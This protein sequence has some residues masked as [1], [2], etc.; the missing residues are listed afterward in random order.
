LQ[1]EAAAEKRTAK[2]RQMEADGKIKRYYGPDNPLWK[3]GHEARLRRYVESG[4]SAEQLRRYRAANPHKARE[5]AQNRRNRKVGK[6]PYGTVPRIGDAQKWRCAICGTGIR[7]GYHVDHIMPIARGGKHEP[8]NIQLL[9]ES[10]NVR[11]N[12]KD[13]IQ[14][15][16]EIGRLL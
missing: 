12:A 16:Q 11:K 5:W 8:R 10:C 1:S 15:M 13:P 9:C 14:Y 3:G 4:R 6:L 7:D 2:R